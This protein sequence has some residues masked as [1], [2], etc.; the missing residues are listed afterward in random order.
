MKRELCTI[1]SPMRLKN[2]IPVDLLNVQCSFRLSSSFRNARHTP[3]T[4]R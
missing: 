4:Q 3:R 1:Q 2:I